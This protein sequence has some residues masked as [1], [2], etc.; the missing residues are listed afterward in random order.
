MREMR[1]KPRNPYITYEKRLPSRTFFSCT[2]FTSTML[3][4][5]SL[6]VFTLNVVMYYKENG[7]AG[8]VLRCIEVYSR[9]SDGVYC[10]WVPEDGLLNWALRHL[11]G[12]GAALSV[13]GLVL[14]LGFRRWQRY[15]YELVRQGRVTA[16]RSIGIPFGYRLQVELEGNT[17]ANEVAR[18]WHTIEDPAE[19]DNLKVG[20]VISI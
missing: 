4:I 17:Y 7:H 12:I 5:L 11:Y 19:W 10:E 14:L 20:Q 13:S 9:I 16:K 15:C 18:C 2:M 3:S 6:V 8:E 1:L